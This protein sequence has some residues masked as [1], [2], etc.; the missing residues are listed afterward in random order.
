MKKSILI[1]GCILSLFILVSISYQPILAEKSIIEI[2]DEKSSV[3][4][5]TFLIGLLREPAKIN[6]TSFVIQ[7]KILF[8][9]EIFNFFGAFRIC[10]NF[11]YIPYS[12]GIHTT[13]DDLEL[14]FVE[15]C[16]D[17]FIC[18]YVALIEII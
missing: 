10:Y 18:G 3:I 7:T 9:F 16:T 12:V 17:N 6:E 11:Y 4:H 2:Q 14:K 1:A 5:R 8:S 15:I 13:T